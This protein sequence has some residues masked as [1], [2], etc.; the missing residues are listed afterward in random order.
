MLSLSF[1]LGYLVAL[2][3]GSVAVFCSCWVLLCCESVP[4]LLG[5]VVMMHCIKYSYQ[6]LCRA[7]RGLA[8]FC[9]DANNILMN[10]SQ[11]HRIPLSIHK[12]HLPSTCTN[13]YEYK[14]IGTE[15][16]PVQHAD[17]SPQNSTEKV[18]A[19]QSIHAAPH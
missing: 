8:L 1:V 15:P 19:M 5:C 4:V 18:P 3:R 7:H 6:F 17:S 16:N 9:H 13:H 11:T 12:Y 14:F 10:H 2:G